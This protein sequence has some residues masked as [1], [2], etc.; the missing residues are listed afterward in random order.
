MKLTERELKE[1][2]LHQSRLDA[3]EWCE[4]HNIS[5]SHIKEINNKIMV[6]VGF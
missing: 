6:I 1:I 4:N 5:K 3:E 2:E